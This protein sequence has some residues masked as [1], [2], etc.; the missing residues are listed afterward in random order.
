MA[1]KLKKKNLFGVGGG[2]VW[3]K[4]NF[5]PPPK[6]NLKK[7]FPFEIPWNGEKIEGKKIEG[8]GQKCMRG[9]H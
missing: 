5:D 6:K 3:A 4:K 2:G 8:G 7:K 9:R 1:R